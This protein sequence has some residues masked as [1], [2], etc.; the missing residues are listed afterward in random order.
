MSE[1][2]IDNTEKA[3][4]LRYLEK[5]KGISD[6]II[7]HSR[8]M[9]TVINRN[10]N[11]EKVNATFCN[12]HKVADDSVVGK[13]LSDVWGHDTFNKYIKRNIDLCFTGETVRYEAA[14]NT[15]KLGRRYFEV[16]FRPISAGSGEITHLLAETTDIDDL[17]QSKL[18]V[19]EKEEEFRTFETN[20]PIGFLRLDQEG[21]ILHANR[22]FL[23]IMEC[24]DEISI[25]GMNIGNFYVEE[26]LF[27]LQLDQLLDCSTKNFGRVYLKNCNKDEIPCRITGY[28]A[29]NDEGTTAYIDLAIEDSSRELMLENRLLQAQKLETIGALAGG[30]AHDFNNIL[31]TISGYAEMLHEDLPKNSEHFDKVGRIQ[32]AVTRGRSITNQILTFSRQVDQEKVQINVA[33]V[34]KETIAFV[35]SAMPAGII[36]KSR[37][38]KTKAFVFADPTQLFRVF[39]NLMTNAFYA[40][41]ENGG[42]LTVSLSVEE[43]KIVKH[44]LNKDIVADEYV[45]ITFKDT[46]K[47]MEPSLIKRIFEPFF[48][49]RD[50]G[51]GTGLGLSVIHGIITELEGEILVSSKKDIGSAFIIYLPVSKKYTDP[52]VQADRRKKI[53]FL[54]GNKHESRILSLALESSGYDLININ[55]SE[56]FIKVMTTTQ[57]QPDLVIYMTDSKQIG[58]RELAA[59]YSR[60]K[61][62]TPCILI[63]D[64]DQE[65][66]EEKL[67]NSGIIKQHLIKPVSLRE[68]SDAIH[69]SIK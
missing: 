17:I 66:M 18:A 61:I 35:K 34:L 53:L 14:F 19:I 55:N 24:H 57:D 11:Y 68:I 51:K 59:I 5:E 47:G 49:T 39:L 4:Y 43:G 45:L 3:D 50:V 38:P 29:V 25:R 44:E 69:S 8:S 32:A 26:G 31:A 60:L 12:A 48:T 36:I 52:L 56:N 46:G 37:I 41:E 7:D 13:S 65:L 30:I 16:I 6:Q 22:A 9:I 33:E 15:P 23:R 67:L 54:T 27:N 64:P 28:V 58:Q 2:K 1:K 40:M 21:N 10:Y 62:S 42:T 63:T 20:L